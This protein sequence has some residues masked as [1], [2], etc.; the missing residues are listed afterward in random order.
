MK[1]KLKMSN[2]SQVRL[3]ARIISFICPVILLAIFILGC[4]PKRESQEYTC[5]MHPEVVKPEPGN[6][7]ICAM[8][9]VLKTKAADETKVSAD[10]NYLLKP[11]NE[12][13]IASI[14]TIAPTQKSVAT[15]IS[16]SGAITYD[17]KNVT[18]IAAR[19]SGR[20]EKIYLHYNF[21]PVKK[22]QKILEIYSAELVAAQRELLYVLQSDKD[23]STLIDAAKEKLRLLGLYESQITDLT[24]SGKESISFAV[25]SPADGYLVA[26]DATEKIS[27]SNTSPQ[28]AMAGGM[29]ESSRKTEKQENATPAA[30]LQLREGMY[31]E[32]GQTLFSVAN[33][34][35][36]WAAFDVAQ[37]Q[38]NL[39]H[40]GDDI[41]R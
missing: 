27:S 9:L 17:T 34:S 40:T 33:T 12:L 26:Q 32:A 24:A 36:V 15:K 30:T 41:P 29:E 13:L 28:K 8:E 4:Q 2:V 39:I 22:S 10:L 18:S 25:Y 14:R 3:M 11:T 16:V 20:I 5:S 19:Y 7:P 31:I 37:S 6:C 38:I 35:S 1:S 23:N 21:Q